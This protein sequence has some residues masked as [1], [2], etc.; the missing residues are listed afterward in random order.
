MINW[1]SG[2]PAVPLPAPRRARAGGGGGVSQL[3]HHPLPGL[4]ATPVPVGPPGLP[5]APS[6]RR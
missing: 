4:T 2:R 1:R 3:F 5:A 6:C